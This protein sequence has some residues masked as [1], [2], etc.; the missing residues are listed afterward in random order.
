MNGAA[1]IYVHVP[2]CRS[3]C[4]FCAFLVTVHDTFL[5]RYVAAVE[6]EIDRATPGWTGRFDT[7]YFGGGTP[8]LLR[9]ATVRRL[10]DRI[11]ERF[12]VARAAEISLEANPEDMSP[13]DLGSLR[14]A[15]VNRLSLGVQSLDDRDLSFLGRQHSSAEAVG[16]IEAAR[17]AGFENLTIDLLYGLPNR[18]LE[19]W[20]S[21]LHRA[22]DLG[23]DHVSAYQLTV[24]PGTPLRVRV[25]KGEVVPIGEEEEREGFLKTREWL[26][27][28]GYTPYEVSSFAR[29]P[30]FESRHNRKYW[31]GAP[32]LGLGPAAHSYRDGRRWWN[33][34]AVRN[35][36]HALEEGRS[37]V[38][39]TEVPTEEETRL[40]RLFLGL[41]TSAGA[42]L[43]LVGPRSR[44]LVP[45]LAAEGLGVL[46][47]ESF[48]LTARGF[49]VADAI[50][51]SLSR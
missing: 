31:E 35:Y 34:G 48:R 51:T 23:P 33:H 22:L 39:S 14:A 10:I 37:P 36:V 16:A 6:A 29:E 7:I 5:D 2:F 24:E 32:Y 9:P 47:G 21:V 19:A 28:A 26:E 12:D 38:E 3:R 11:R 25:R 49:A 15:G 43:S 50:A 46:D 4:P 8:S 42:P 41:R 13:R 45:A 27:A 44:P 40:E 20:R 17:A 30:R 1:G 18:S